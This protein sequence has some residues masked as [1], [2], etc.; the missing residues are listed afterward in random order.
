LVSTATRGRS[1][2]T[3]SSWND[4]ISQT[5]HAAGSTAPTSAVR[6]RPMFPATSAGTPAASN[7]APSSAVVVV[8]PFVPVMP[9][10]CISRL[11]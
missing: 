4:E 11:G 9:T 1:V 10:T 7:I 3:S 2:S 8:L 6:G 5:T